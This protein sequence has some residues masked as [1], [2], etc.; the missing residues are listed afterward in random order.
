MKNIFIL[1][2]IFL[3]CACNSN[4]DTY[5]LSGKAIGFEDGTKI[6]VS[7]VI[8]NQPKAIDTL[9]VQS[10][11]FLGEYPNSEALTLNLL[12]VENVKSTILYFPENINLKATI[13]KDSIKSS[14]VNGGIQN[15]T[16]RKF[17]NQLKKFN[18]IKTK[19]AQLFKQARR[20]QDG[21]LAQDLQLE[22]NNIAVQENDY[23]I[24]FVTENPNS[25]FSVLLLTELVSKKEISSID[26]TKI[27]NSYS[28]KI[29]ASSSSKTLK[30]TIAAMKKAEVGGQAPDFSAP[31]P[32][33]EN[34]ALS[35]VLGKYT[36][37][38]FWASWCKPCRREN[39]NVVN[40]YNEYHKKGLNIISVS[41]DKAG[42]K[43]RWLKAIETDQM[44]WEHVSN[45][46]GWK[47]PIAKMYNV[48]SIPATFLLDE[49]GTIIAKNL[50]GPALGQK[51][52]SLL[53]KN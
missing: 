17:T 36:I 4:S 41:L 15:D 14:F 49:N 53:G 46:K 11:L 6:I 43:E 8:N 20:E 47:E 18:K 32:S 3:L 10:E 2:S 44:N 42:Q 27:I 25:L 1:I 7:E 39:P 51:I 21:I 30:N 45:L 12:Q 40:V 24:K 19:K 23:K 16:Y 29:A 5:T 33:G 38:D 37:I 31:T 50:R 26:A 35:D 48:R 22:L 9:L 52:A 13:F 34:L 28:P